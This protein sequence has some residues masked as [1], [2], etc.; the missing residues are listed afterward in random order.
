[1]RSLPTPRIM[2]VSSM[3]AG[4]RGRRGSC[5]RMAIA[6]RWRQ[7]LRE[8][9]SF[10]RRLIVTDTLFSM[11]GDLAPLVRLAELAEQYDAMLMVDEAH[12]TGVFGAAGPR[13]C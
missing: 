6:M 11:D 2:P 4:C 8:A 9:G 7:Q 3:A 12:A 5:I 10:R 13:S 1:M